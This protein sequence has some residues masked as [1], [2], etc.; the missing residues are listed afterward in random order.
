MS[1][2]AVYEELRS[3]QYY[4]VREAKHNAPAA[5]S[6]RRTQRKGTGFKVKQILRVLPDSKKKLVRKETAFGGVEQVVGE[7]C[8]ASCFD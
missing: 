4:T 1:D 7:L 5:P 2:V 3:E 6:A 8:S